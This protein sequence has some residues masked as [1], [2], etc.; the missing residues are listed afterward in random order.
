M[1]K[2][3]FK[4]KNNINAIGID[5][6]D[7][8]SEK[9]IDGF[10]HFVACPHFNT[11]KRIVRLLQAL[12]WDVLG[13]QQFSEEVRNKVYE[14][15]FP[16]KVTSKGLNVKQRKRLSTKLTDL[17]RLAER[18]L[19]FEALEGNKACRIDFICQKLLEK[20]Q[21]LLFNR[22]V[23][24][25]EKNLAEQNHKGRI[26]HNRHY[27]LA[28]NVM[29]YL[30]QTGEIYKKD[31]LPEV[32]YHLDIRHFLE[33]LKLYVT[34][35]SKKG[36][37]E[38]VYDTASM[39]VTLQ[40]LDLPQ[41]A[42]H[43]MLEVYKAIIRLMKTQDE[44]AY[45]TL[46]SVLKLNLSYIPKVDLSLFYATLTN[47]C[48]RQIN[49]GQFD[50][51]DL[52]ELY[53]TIESKNLLIEG[54]FVSSVS[55]KSAVICACRTDE[56]E[57]AK[58]I[59][60]KYKSL[61]RKPIRESVYNFN[62]GV[63]TFYQK[64]YSAAL[65][66]FIRVDDVSTDYDI[67]CRIMLMKSYYETDEDYDERTVQIFRAT[68]KFFKENKRL[69]ST[70]KRGYKNFVRILIHVYK[71]RHRSTKMTL[72]SIKERLNKQEVNSDKNWL[73]EKIGEL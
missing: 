52:F 32:L 33:K 37:N 72:E 56:F 44:A 12:K 17:T 7:S 4:T 21:Y 41:Y 31:N 29:N 65:H 58:A 48:I 22:T 13:K 68:E 51:Y 2:N 6:L 3:N 19:A 47:F 35:L 60:E 11:D 64:N 27:K 70:R 42:G 18:F 53:Q 46:S 26:Y 66:H 69:S 50:Y 10:R 5:L 45:R 30:Y 57:W 9:E 43:P 73:L 55:L 36:R 34:M 15:V 63:I 24:R 38:E 8:F 40:L 25:E 23:K 54:D 67:N 28:K 49:K 62:L 14:K 39:E 71:F 16:D 1:S 20:K 59:I 61:I